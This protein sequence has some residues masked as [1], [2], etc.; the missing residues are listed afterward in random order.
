MPAP[1]AFNTCTLPLGRPGP[2]RGFTLVEV[3]TVCAIAGVLVTV[4]WPSLK[5]NLV[6][7][8]RGDAV[9]AL[10]KVQQ[11]QANHH[12]LHGLYAHELRALG[13]L[14]DNTPQGMYTLAL[15]AVHGDGYVASAT[16]RPDSRQ[17]DD[18]G[19]NRLTLEVRRGF[20]NHGPSPR[21]WQP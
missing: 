14:S 11:A 16:A 17:A 5:P 20:A 1:A 9:H 15:E 21:C 6:R 19:C 2:V 12:A 18:I 10:T 8:G 3:A 7:A 13:V 4:A